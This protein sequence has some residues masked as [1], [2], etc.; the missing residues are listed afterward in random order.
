MTSHRASDHLPIRCIE[1]G[2]PEWP[3]TLDALADPPDRLWAYGHGS[4]T[5]LTER[6]VGVIGSRPPNTAISP[7]RSWPTT[8]RV[9]A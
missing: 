1:R 7:R 6:A 3:T 9:R 4:L 2:S 5:A 8:C